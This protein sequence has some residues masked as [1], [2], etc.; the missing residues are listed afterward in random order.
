M[1]VVEK[2]VPKIPSPKKERPMCVGRIDEIRAVRAGVE[3]ALALQVSRV[4][5]N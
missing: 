5:T 3:S 2:M 1:R 4:C